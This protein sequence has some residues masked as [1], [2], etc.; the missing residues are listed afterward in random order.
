MIRCG[1][2]ILGQCFLFV[3]YCMLRSTKIVCKI[4]ALGLESSDI[5][6]EHYHLQNTEMDRFYFYLY[7]ISSER[8]FSGYIR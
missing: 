5:L 2:S 4:D 3:K 8:I 7:C 6:E 1:L